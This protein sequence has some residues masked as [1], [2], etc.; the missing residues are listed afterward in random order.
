MSQNSQQG[1]RHN[2]PNVFCHIIVKFQIYGALQGRRS[3]KGFTARR[4]N[5]IQSVQESDRGDIRL[6]RRCLQSFFK[7][8]PRNIITNVSVCH[9]PVCFCA[10]KSIE[11]FETF[12]GCSMF[13]PRRNSN[14]SINKLLCR[15]GKVF[16]NKFFSR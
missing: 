15:G 9:R 2:F 6:N 16:G 1:E 4:V 11:I 8:S 3:Q 5:T 10:P 14:R 13:F 7:N 12:L